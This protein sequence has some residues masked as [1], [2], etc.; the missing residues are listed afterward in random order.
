[1]IMKRKII[2]KEKI[3]ILNKKETIYILFF[4]ISFIFSLYLTNY[5]I[6]KDRQIEEVELKGIYSKYRRNDR[7]VYTKIDIIKPIDAKS[8]PLPSCILIHGD[9]V[10]PESMNIVIK[11]LIDNGYLVAVTDFKNFEILPTLSKLEAVLDYLLQRPDVNPDQIGV[12]G[13]SHGGEF[14]LL[15]GIIRENDINAVICGNFANWNIFSF[16]RWTLDFSIDYEFIFNSTV[17]NNVLFTLEE[18]DERSGMESEQFLYNL[19]DGQFDQAEKFYGNFAA[20]TAREIYY[21]S[22]VFNHVSS[23]F[24]SYTIHK[25]IYWLNQALNS[26]SEIFIPQ[27]HTPREIAT[28]IR[29]VFFLIIIE[30]FL[31]YQILKTIILILSN[32][33]LIIKS[34]NLYFSKKIPYWKKK[35]SNRKFLKNGIS[36]QIF[37]KPQIIV[38]SVQRDYQERVWVYYKTIKKE[39]DKLIP[40]RKNDI[41]LFQENKLILKNLDNKKFWKTTLLYLACIWISALFFKTVLEFLLQNQLLSREFIF[42]FIDYFSKPTLLI[43][44]DFFRFKFVE[45]YLIVVFSITILVLRKQPELKKLGDYSYSH[46]I[47]GFLVSLEIYLFF[48]LFLSLILSDIT[49][50]LAPSFDLRNILIFLPFFYFVNLFVFEFFYNRISG[51][52]YVRLKSIGIQ[53]CIYLPLM[54]PE[55]FNNQVVPEF[56]ISLL[57]VIIL[58]PKIY[59]NFKNFK[60]IA[61]FDYF[62]MISIFAHL[63]F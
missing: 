34:T 37:D 49:G 15:L 26:N 23:L 25:E 45:L 27:I 18:Y 31:A 1:M 30:C 9:K 61:F 22:T 51:T 19:T 41:E 58:N 10:G 53:L 52:K 55:I 2:V 46:S 13:H 57:I 40:A 8:G 5:I 6:Y 21:S 3:K 38:D 17:P 59:E 16:A 48:A 39:D 42:V 44:D 62:F 20:G 4:I 60:M 29:S 28:F 14:A 54:I 24:S 33:D 7:S 47:K 36:N 50:D 32:Q 35:I 11:E 63:H 56:F 43:I 12:L